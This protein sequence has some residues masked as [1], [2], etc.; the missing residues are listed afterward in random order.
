MIALAKPQAETL[1]VIIEHVIWHKAEDGYSVI[2]V[3][4][5]KASDPNGDLFNPGDLIDDAFV[6]VGYMPKIREGDEYTI[7]GTWKSH[8][9]FGQQFAFTDHELLL[10][11]TEKGIISFLTTAAFGIGRVRAKKI[12][13]ALGS[14]C[15]EIIPEKGPVALAGIDGITQEQAQEI[16]SN[17]TSNQVLAELTALICREGI[18]P[19][20]TTRIYNQY[21]QDAVKTVK[22]NPYVLAD[23]LW[24]VGFKKADAV[25]QAVGIASDSQFRVK[26]AIDYILKEAGSEG[27]CYLRP[28]DIIA[29]LDKLLGKGSGVVKD[30]VKTANETLIREGKCIREGNAVYHVGLYEAEK[31]LATRMRVL[32]SQ[33]K[34]DVP[35]LE[36]LIDRIEEDNGIIYA[37]QQREAVRTALTNRESIVTGGPGTG[38]S[39]VINGIV[40]AY[41]ILAIEIY[42]LVV[43]NEDSVD[44]E[45]SVYLSAPTGRASKRMT[46]TTSKEAKTIHRLLRY[47]PMLGGFE[48]HEGNQLEPGLLIVDEFSM[49]DVL[50]G[51]DLF[52]AIPNEMTVVMVGDVDQLPSVGP[53]SVLRD[54]IESGVIPTVRLEYNYR[55][56]SGSMI[57]HYANQ[58]CK[59][60]VPD[61]C[62]QHSDFITYFVDD[63]DQAAGLIKNLV[64]NIVDEGYGI[65]DFQILPPMRKGVAGVNNLNDIVREVVNPA[66]P[67]KPELKYGNQ[68]F[69]VSDKVMVTK[70]NYKLMVF[71]G[72]IGQ[73]VDISS[74][75]GKGAG[76]Y[77]SIEGGEPVFFGYEDIGIITLAYASTVHK[78][79]GSEFPIVI[80]PCLKSH[81]IMLN[82]KIIYTAI[83]RAKK[84]LILVCQPDAVEIAVKNDKSADRFSLLKER[85]REGVEAGE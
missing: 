69:R 37:A 57:A 75:G 36:Q 9:K 72:D 68:V 71:N 46:E 29:K 2:R 6:A 42:M 58:I 21:G 44:E 11:T 19:S 78:A 41:E 55:Q 33:L 40:A 14:N 10:P 53:G 83:T 35:G 56:A 22:E 74:G 50:L 79:Q 17:L 77:V 84:K 80:V 60:I 45:P 66:T 31:R 13:D 59:G 5:A 8:P 62:A 34:Q 65:M 85:L 12:Y 52:D 67:G 16:Y 1:R 76:L 47:N 64:R 82:R 38:K 48:Y 61:L 23:D 28:R 43:T 3:A 32:A 20:L 73:V 7:T 49:V 25:A 70:N 27:H 26:A 81:Y 4:P 24:G 18:T 15:L 54:A 39:T 51:A 30:D 63:A